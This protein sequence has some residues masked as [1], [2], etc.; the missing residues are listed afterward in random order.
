MPDTAVIEALQ[1]LPPVVRQ[2]IDLVRI[3]NAKYPDILPRLRNAIYSSY[4]KSHGME[5]GLK[6]YNEVVVMVH[7]YLQSN[8]VDPQLE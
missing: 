1:S 2:S 8:S 6:S 4:L 7:H 5:S 3:N